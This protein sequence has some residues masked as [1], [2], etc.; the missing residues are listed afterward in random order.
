MLEYELIRA[1]QPDLI[2]VR[3]ALSIEK[4]VFIDKTRIAEPG[5]L[6]SISE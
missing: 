6:A 3:D 5:Y 2:K 4:K 1:Y